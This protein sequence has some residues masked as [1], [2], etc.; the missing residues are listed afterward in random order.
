ME[1]ENV[2]TGKIAGG[3][4]FKFQATKTSHTKGRMGSNKERNC[5]GVT[6]KWD[7]GSYLIVV[8]ITTPP[9]QH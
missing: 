3:G 6:M 8:T 1:A 4:S 9:L 5:T 2:K 7:C